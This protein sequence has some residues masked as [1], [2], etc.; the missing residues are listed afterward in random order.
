M[1]EPVTLSISF[2]LEAW[3]AA[4]DSIKKA[5]RELWLEYQDVL[6]NLANEARR[7]FESLREVLEPTPK[8][9]NSNK[10]LFRGYR[11]TQQYNVQQQLQKHQTKINVNNRHWQK[12][13][14][15]Y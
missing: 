4:I 11:L 3:Q 8:V 9:R 10:Q 14:R 1:I 12:H 15:K 7:A 5:I 13:R 2:D 6:K